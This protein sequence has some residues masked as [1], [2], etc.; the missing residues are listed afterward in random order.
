M[1]QHI[2]V[3]RRKTSV[4]RVFLRKGTG[5]VTIN[6]TRSPESIL[7]RKELVLEA[8]RPL[9]VVNQ[10][11]QWDTVVRVSG[12]GTSGQSQAIS[13]GIARALLQADEQLRDVLR[14]HKL[15]TRDSRIVE[16]K[17]YGQAGARK[18]FQFSKR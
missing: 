11:E 8:L 13:L 17:K 2:G 12:G 16:R 10:Q 15:L 1:E 14:Q 4:A 6:K 7:H 18:K 5:K 3:G 9:S